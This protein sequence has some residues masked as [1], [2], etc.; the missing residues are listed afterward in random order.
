VCKYFKSIKCFHSCGNKDIIGGKFHKIFTIHKLTIVHVVPD[1]ITA[2]IK[3][4][5]MAARYE[6]KTLCNLRQYDVHVKSHGI[7]SIS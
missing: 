2:A 1:F 4:L 5:L 6:V 7:L 3:V